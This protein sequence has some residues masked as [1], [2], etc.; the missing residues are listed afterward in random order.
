MHQV[1]DISKQ[2]LK[3]LDGE[4]LRE[5]V[6]R[7]CEA[8]LTKTGAPVSPVRWSGAH[9][10]AD[11]GLDVDCRVESE[12][13]RGDFVPRTRAGFQVKKSSMPA[14]KI[15][16]EMSPGG[17]LR[18]I[19]AE[20]AKSDGCYIIVS[21]EDDP[22]PNGKPL[23]A[24]RRA[25]R[26]QVA[27]LQDLG[28]LQTEFYGRH[29][30]AQ[31]LRQ[32]PGVQLWARERLGIP[33]RGWKS[34]GRWTRTPPGDND[35]LICGSGVSVVLPGQDAEKL[36]IKDGIQG[37]R[38]LVRSSDKAVRIV[39]LSGV[40]KTRIVQALFED[41]VGTN[42]LDKNLAVYA[43][44]GEEPD[45]SAR[46]MLE[47]LRAQGHPGIVVLD[48]CP[49]DS[50]NSLA[51]LVVGLPDLWLITV[52]YDIRDDRTEHTEFVRID[53][54][55]PEIVEALV[56][57]RYPDRGQIDARRIAEFSGGNARMALALAAAVDNTESLSD[58]SDTELF[59]RLFHQRGGL[60]QPLLEAAEI[61]SLV[62]SFSVSSDQE[63][64]D[65][66]AV[67]A[68]LAG[69]DRRAMYREAQTL[70]E[71][72]LVQKRGH[73]RAVLPPAVSYRLASKAL[74]AVPADDILDALVGL[75]APR[76][77]I[78]FGK[79]LGYLHEHEV[80]REIV[81]TWLA[82]GG[83]L[84]E[85]EHLNDAGLRLLTNVAPV[86]PNAI[87]RT[88]EARIGTLD[89]GHPDSIGAL[90]G[91]VIEEILCAIAYDAE[92]FERSVNLL[93][94]IALSKTE[95][96]GPTDS[97][98]R[99]SALFSLYLSGTSA[100]LDTRARIVRHYLFSADRRE[101]EL[102]FRMLE[103]ALKRNRHAPLRQYD[104][105][106]RPRPHGYFPDSHE[107]RDRWFH[108]FVDMAR[109]V[110][111][112]KDL[113]LSNRSRVLLADQL[114]SLWHYPTL[115]RDLVAVSKAL[116]DQRPWLKGWRAVR[117]IK[118]GLHRKPDDE[119]KPSDA[120]LLNQLDDMLRPTGLADSIRSHVLVSDQHWFALDIEF[121][122]NDERN[123]EAS[124][125]RA[126]DRA[127]E[128]GEVAALDLAV[129]DELAHEVYAAIAGCLQAFGKGLA[130]NCADPH[131]LWI[132]LVAH[133]ERAGD[134]VR[135][136]QV[137]C[138]FLQVISKRDRSLAENILD[139]A[140]KSDSLRRF[141]VDLQTSV[142]LDRRGV[143]RLLISLD[144]DDIPLDQFGHLAWHHPLDA[145][146]ETDLFDLMLKVMAQ[147]G[148]ARVVLGGLHMRF[149]S[150]KANCAGFPSTDI[151]GVGLCAAAQIFREFVS[152]ESD[153]VDR[154]LSAVL[155][156]CMDDTAFPRE[157]DE[158]LDSFVAG[159]QVSQGYVGDLNETVAVL[160]AKA[161]LRFLDRVLLGEMRNDFH[162]SI[163][164]EGALG[165]KNP[166][167]GIDPAILL[168]WCRQGDLQARLLS[169]SE[170]IFPF[171]EE[172]DGGA[173][174]FS[175]Q[176]HA[177]IDEAQDVSAILTS[178]AA[179]TRHSHEQGWLSDTIARRI[180][181][182][183][184]LLS[185]TRLRVRQAAEALVPQLREFEHRVRQREQDEEG[186]RDQSFE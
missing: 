27:G 133:L 138:G 15:A 22:T 122:D 164:F 50:H 155:E 128:L 47:R 61:L 10:A 19:F 182:F 82:P 97:R 140:L 30:L 147:P 134:D 20:L 102:G 98:D 94:R 25:M 121:D 103:A 29:Q 149:H 184:A 157:T 162:R 151:K 28:D 53:A 93:A 7:L 169:I 165:G 143:E 111:T 36:E 174:D 31:W 158:L 154:Q 75:P 178:F 117:S 99:L 153:M 136:C 73:W 123:W 119:A 175:E 55:S 24:R 39:G 118:H 69:R 161:P 79:R 179:S 40:G 60:N 57:R 163:L 124:R 131:G 112:G 87:L 23:A 33:L 4:A 18:P 62:Y 90:Q 95:E 43:D 130:S 78:S 88:I 84:H 59:D 168:D 150:L 145:L 71:R 37:I 139:Q 96:H 81:G 144:F 142:A 108:H 16:T 3:Q 180:R 56:R 41:A 9:T 21:L 72:Q 6:A 80:A 86:D 100:G 166:L 115:R 77:L 160:A 101:R 159:L 141:V 183:E 107:E 132:R 74:N 1:I 170:A 58:F 185:D 120:N 127:F 67:L 13:F 92:L 113:G 70:V 35:S 173:V 12:P 8:E 167:C 46:V 148:G 54:E 116:H 181:P 137:L 66:L 11:G 63:G 89:A 44:L 5:L 125:R 135:N 186:Q 38:Q 68:G 26:E 14:G 52:E 104:F 76:L 42:P 146:V 45:P 152:P 109:E 176:A 85:I 91:C 106:A 126:A 171:K 2:Q 49:P 110:G 34:F 172:K 105:G 51:G 32:H 65:E 48:N 64:V 156:I 129:I 17:Q 83:P 177:V 114:Q